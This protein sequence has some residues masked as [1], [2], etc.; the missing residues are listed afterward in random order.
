MDREKRFWDKTRKNQDNDCIEWTGHKSPQGYGQFGYNGKIQKAHR[1]SWQIHRG[2][3]P[4]GI[5]V[6]HTCDNRGCVNL[7]HLWLGTDQDNT[8]DMFSKGRGIKAKGENHYKSKLTW[9]KVESIR[10][11]YADGGVTMEELAKEFEVTSANIYHIV[12]YKIWR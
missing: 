9:E 1:V 5:H 6:L 10:I 3:I 7:D 4:A 8:D 2:E 12:H 11:R